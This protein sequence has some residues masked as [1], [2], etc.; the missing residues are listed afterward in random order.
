MDWIT[1]SISS[2][3]HHSRKYTSRMI[4]ISTTGIIIQRI[5]KQFILQQQTKYSLFSQAQ[6]AQQQPDTPYCD[7]SSWSL[8]DLFDLLLFFSSI[9]SSPIN[10]S[11]ASSP[12]SSIS[13]NFTIY[14]LSLRFFNSAI[15]KII[16]IIE[17]LS[18]FVKFDFIVFRI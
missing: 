2:K 4:N 13:D 17:L 14:S 7:S 10:P 11:S 16:N 18:F 8:F 3:F 12:P 15:L 6:H 1:A 9:W 5:T